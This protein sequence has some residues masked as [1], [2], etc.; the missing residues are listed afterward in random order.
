MTLVQPLDNVQDC[1]KEMYFCFLF[2]QK[3]HM[4][5]MIW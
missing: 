2:T 3:D 4:V 1:G 5:W